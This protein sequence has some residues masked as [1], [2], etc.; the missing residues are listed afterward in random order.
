MFFSQYLLKILLLQL[1][2]SFWLPTAGPPPSLEFEKNSLAEKMT[3]KAAAEQTGGDRLI[4]A[5]LHPDDFRTLPLALSRSEREP[6]RREDAADFNLKALSAQAA[7]VMDSET[8]KVL[9]AY[10]E[11]EKRSIGSLTKL[12]TALVFLETRPDWDKIITIEENDSGQGRLYLAEG[13]IA[14]VRVLFN[15]ALVSSSN[16]ATLALARS[17]GLLLEEFTA[18]MNAKAREMGLFNT[19]FTEP[20]GLDPANQ[21]TARE[22]TLFLKAA[23]SE[24]LIKEAVGQK[25]YSFQLSNGQRRQTDSTNL[26]LFEK[27]PQGKLKSVIGGKTGF[28]EEAGYCFAFA[29]ENEAGRQI[30]TVVLGSGSHFSRFSEAKAL[31]QWAFGVYEW[32]NKEF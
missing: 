1:L 10:R 15:V 29:A 20:T 16:N 31:A 27:F 18:R 12:M 24:K 22:V 19:H 13:E 11:N 4:L 3:E 2:T 26:L 30:I 8:N 6:R 23:L 21:S 7:Y 9:F 14:T 5:P 32:P 25:K 28:V 17:T